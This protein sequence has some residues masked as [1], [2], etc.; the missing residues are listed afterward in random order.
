MRAFDLLPSPR[1]VWAALTLLERARHLSASTLVK[2]TEER[3][4]VGDYVNQDFTR[5]R[6]PTG[7][8]A[9]RA[10]PPRNRPHPAVFRRRAGANKTR[11]A[12]CQDRG[13]RE[14]ARTRCR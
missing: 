8:A 10:A 6:L 14:S 1:P 9:G 4:T 13:R 3:L 7:P 12:R 5:E 11:V 2:H